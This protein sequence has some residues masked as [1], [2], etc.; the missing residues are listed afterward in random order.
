MSVG[1][2]RSRASRK[3]FGTGRVARERSW[4]TRHTARET[5]EACIAKVVVLSR[6]GRGEE[7]AVRGPSFEVTRL[8]SWRRENF[9]WDD[10][11]KEKKTRELGAV[12]GA[13]RAV[14]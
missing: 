8:R 11:S 6:R 4:K 12:L 5:Q 1:R 2:E 3:K 13:C 7:G 14:R 9:E 10:D